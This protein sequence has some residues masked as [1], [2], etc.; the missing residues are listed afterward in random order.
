MELYVEEIAEKLGVTQDTPNRLRPTLHDSIA[1][2]FFPHFEKIV[3]DSGAVFVAQLVRDL[4]PL[5]RS[6]SQGKFIKPYGLAA[7]TT[8]I[9]KLTDEM[10]SEWGLETISL[11]DAVERAYGEFDGFKIM[12]P[13]KKESN[14]GIVSCTSNLLYKPANEGRLEDFVRLHTTNPRN[15]LMIDYKP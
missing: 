2:H 5:I 11:R 3:D 14:I 13:A 6:S 12:N 10:G 7:L 9:M 8:R 15:V 4:A 1:H